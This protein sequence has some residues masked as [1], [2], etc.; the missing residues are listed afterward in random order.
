MASP[1]D[2]VKDSSIWKNPTNYAALDRK[3]PYLRLGIIQRVFQDTDTTEIRYLVD[4]RDTN[5]NV[6]LNCRMMRRFGGV[7]NYED[8]VMQGYTVTDADD[9]VTSFDAKAGD[10]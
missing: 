9:P 7:Y 6:P 8:V 1:F 10:V 5:D 3:D 4:M 2:I